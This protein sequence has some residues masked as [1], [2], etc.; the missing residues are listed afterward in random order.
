[1]KRFLILNGQSLFGDTDS[2]DDALA[3]SK[4]G[5]TVGCYVPPPAL[6]SLVNFIVESG[7]AAEARLLRRQ[8]KIDRLAVDPRCDYCGNR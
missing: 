1:M 2:I 6:W 4:L 8:F 3:W 7:A 5:V